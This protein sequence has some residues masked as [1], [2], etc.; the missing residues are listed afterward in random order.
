M[1]A[2]RS[3][4]LIITYSRNGVNIHCPCLSNPPYLNP[5]NL[6][7]LPYPLMLAKTI[8]ILQAQSLFKLDRSIPLRARSSFPSLYCAY[9]PGHVAATFP[10]HASRAPMLPKSDVLFRAL[11]RVTNGLLS[12]HSR[13]LPNASDLW[14]AP[15]SREAGLHRFSASEMRVRGPCKLAKHKQ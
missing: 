10:K 13:W 6:S 3:E 9:I 7:S 2:W 4:R 8:S 1:H 5:A 15:H 14:W 12:F 11:G